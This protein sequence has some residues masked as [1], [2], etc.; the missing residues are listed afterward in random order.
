LL[1]VGLA[2]ELE[3]AETLLAVAGVLTL[4]PFWFGGSFG[5]LILRLG[6]VGVDAAIGEAVITFNFAGSC[7]V[8]VWLLGVVFVCILILLVRVC[9]AER[10][11]TDG[12][13]NNV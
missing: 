9:I 8:G 3:A 4:V 11:C 10:V 7:P 5:V 12:V 1:S 2:L 6:T 13:Y